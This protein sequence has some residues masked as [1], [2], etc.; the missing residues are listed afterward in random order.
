[1]AAAVDGSQPVANPPLATVPDTRV[2]T[3]KAPGPV[4]AAAAAPPANVSNRT[5]RLSTKQNTS[6]DRPAEVLPNSS[7]IAQLLAVAPTLV[8]PPP[9][10]V[11]QTQPDSPNSSV[12]TEASKAPDANVASPATLPTAPQLAPDVAFAARVV[13]K[14]PAQ[15]AAEDS[16][17]QSSS[18]SPEIATL[19]SPAYFQTT[20]IPV[21]RVEHSGW[22]SHPETQYREALRKEKTSVSPELRAEEPAVLNPAELINNSARPAPVDTPMPLGDNSSARAESQSPAS[23]SHPPQPAQTPSMEMRPTQP[24][25]DVTVRLTSDAQQVDVKLTDRGGE[26][27]VEVHSADPILTTDL[28]ARV[29]D[30]IGGL[31]KSGFHAEAWQPGESPRHNSEGTAGATRGAGNQPQPQSN[32]DPRRQGRNTYDPI[33]A[34]SRRN[35]SS[36]L[37]WM[38]QM[39]ALTSAERKV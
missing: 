26:L 34:P 24:V 11:A 28:R 19:N 10:L 17:V 6:K 8:P 39:N 36:N 15:P 20:A 30:L 32:D 25:R 4:T 1:M 27:H 35:R 22:E 18:S 12:D 23:E 9:T 37:E 7:P 31:E 5:S 3:V 33:P 13:E 38:N 14:E 21:N 29:H 2:P 16:F